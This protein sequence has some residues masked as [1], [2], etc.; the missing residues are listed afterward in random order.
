MESLRWASR[1]SVRAGASPC[2]RAISA[3]LRP[4]SVR[5][6]PLVTRMPSAA[7]TS[8][9]TVSASAESPKFRSGNRTVIVECQ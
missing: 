8:L 1:I 2:S 3:R 9:S 6:A 7:A 4:R 5:S